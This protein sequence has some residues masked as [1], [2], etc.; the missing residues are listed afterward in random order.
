M[1]LRELL[2]EYGITTIT[3]FAARAQMSKAQAWALWH[4]RNRLG[5]KLARQIAERTGIPL[6]KLVTLD[7]TPPTPSRG[8]GGPRKHRPPAPEKGAAEGSP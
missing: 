1:I 8:R 5:L 4:G 3:A 7:P 2:A 6:E